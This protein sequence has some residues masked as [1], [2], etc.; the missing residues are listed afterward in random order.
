MCFSFCLVEDVRYFGFAVKFTQKEGFWVKNSC[1][2]GFFRILREMFCKRT[3]AHP[4]EH[5][6]E[7][8]DDRPNER[9]FGCSDARTFAR[10]AHT[11]PGALPA[12]LS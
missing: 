7:H 5:T 12:F 10:P 11:L 1:Q 8:L 3:L 4:N 9:L 6:N 2:I